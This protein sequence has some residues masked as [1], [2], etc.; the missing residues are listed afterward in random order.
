LSTASKSEVVVLVAPPEKT[1]G[2][3]AKFADDVRLDDV[4]VLL[5]VHAARQ[6]TRDVV[7]HPR[8]QRLNPQ[9]RL[10]TVVRLLLDPVTRRVRQRALQTG[11]GL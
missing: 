10:E 1:A 7:M 3:T 2:R 6:I 8:G 5:G 11:K 4:V 9:S